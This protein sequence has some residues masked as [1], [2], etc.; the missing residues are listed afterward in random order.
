MVNKLWMVFVDGVFDVEKNLAYEIEVLEG[1][2]EPGELDGWFEGE[3][4]I[5]FGEFGFEVV[6]G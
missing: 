2:R 1:A 3:G 4:G 5:E 6:E